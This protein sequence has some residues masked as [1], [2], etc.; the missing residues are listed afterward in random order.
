MPTLQDIVG[1]LQNSDRVRLIKDNKD[2]YV[3]WLANLI[4]AHGLGTQELLYQKYKDAEVIKFR[5]VNEV[6][7]RNWKELG[8]TSPLEPNEAA[9]YSF[10]DME[11]KLYYTIYI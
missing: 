9:D 5:A 8:L 3:G 1:L 6:R 7:H 4:K 10:T 11:Q 2:V